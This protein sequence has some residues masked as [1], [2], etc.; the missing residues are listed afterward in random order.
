MPSP[1]AGECWRVCILLPRHTPARQHRAPSRRRVPAAVALDASILLEVLTPLVPSLFLPMASA[2]NVGPCAPPEPRPARASRHAVRGREGKNVSW[3]AASASR[4]GI[5][6]SLA[7]SDNLADV[8]AKTGSQTIAASLLGTEA[9]AAPAAPPTRALTCPSSS[10]TAGTG[11]GIALSPLLGPSTSAVLPA[12]LA[13]SAAHIWAN[14]LAVR[15]VS[16]PTLS[17]RV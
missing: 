1:S 14:V 16:L 5:H 10:P 15:H 11:V 13:L 4:A 6:A 3:L 12:A 17:A 9:A 8:T 2:A 7:V